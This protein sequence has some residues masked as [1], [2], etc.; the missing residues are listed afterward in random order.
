MQ[1]FFDLGQKEEWVWPCVAS[2]MWRLMQ[3]EKIGQAAET[4]EWGRKMRRKQ[5]FYPEFSRRLCNQH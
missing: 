3:E 5:H 4:G 1:T 2:V